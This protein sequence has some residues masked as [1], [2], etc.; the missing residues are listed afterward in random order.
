VGR[1]QWGGASGDGSTAPSGPTLVGITPRL[2]YRVHL[3]P[4]DVAIVRLSA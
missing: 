1:R 3:S 2:A 4:D